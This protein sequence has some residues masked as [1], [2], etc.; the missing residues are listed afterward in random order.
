MGRK[1]VKCKTIFKT[2]IEPDKT[3]R[4][5]TRMTMKGFMLQPGIDYKDTFS[6]VAS[7]TSTRMAISIYLY[8]EK[9]LPENTDIKFNIDMIDIEA[10]FLEGKLPKPVYIEFPPGLL[11]VGMISEEE[12]KTKCI[13]L[14]GGMYGSPESAIQFFRE[15]SNHLKQNGYQ[16]SRMD[17]SVF[18]KKDEAG[19]TVLIAVIHVDDT[20]I[21]GTKEEINKFKTIV[22]QR[23]GYTDK[24]GFKKHLG[25]WYE[26]QEDKDKNKCIIATMKDT[27]QN[28][29]A[30]FENHYTRGQ[31]QES[32]TPGK[33]G[34]TMAKMKNQQLTQ[35]SIEKLSENHIFGV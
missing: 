19:R 26:E 8:G 33:P 35:K 25:V 16:Q 21:V 24:D 5:K 3:C 9:G 13:E 14:S 17:P 29:I 7:E 18:F 22:G 11:E 20:L 32:N 30:T 6:P 15:Y 10:A 12:S 34:N 27:V 2:K 4:F 23:F 28:I 31:L 1:I